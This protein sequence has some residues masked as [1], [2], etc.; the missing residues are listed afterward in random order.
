M[1]VAISNIAWPIE[2]DSAVANMLARQG[3]QAIEVAP[4]KIWPA[5]LEASGADVKKYR[6]EW[7]RRGIRIVA[8]Q[9]LLFGK[10]EL[11]VFDDD[12][13]RRRTLD[14]LDF[15]IG[16]CADLGA[17]SLVFG[18]PKNRRIEGLAADVVERIAVDFFG[19]LGEKAASRGTAIVMEANPSEYGADFL[20]RACEAVSLVRKVNHPGFRLHLDSACMTLSGDAVDEVVGE[21]APWLHHFHVSEPQLA[22][23]GTGGVEHEKFARALNT[24][25]YDRWCSVEMRMVEP[26]TIGG[27][28]AAIKVA[29]KTYTGRTSG[30]EPVPQKRNV[31]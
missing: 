29:N 7:G 22:A 30:Q 27:L 14:Y 5:P 12:P 10:P 31:G 18:S 13:T 24:A 8:A 9:A 4:T 19:R 16:L 21:G 17:E 20:T 25:A 23:I 3:V 11:T 1:R 28:E 15:I 26:F 6:Q 2:D